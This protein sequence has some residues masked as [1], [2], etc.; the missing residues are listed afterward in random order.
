MP[1]F[2]FVGNSLSPEETGLGKI[3]TNTT[4]RSNTISWVQI[5]TQT[6]NPLDE[7]SDTCDSKNQEKICG[8]SRRSFRI[9]NDE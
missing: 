6:R 7:Q 5:E 9:E 8:R 1:I 3:S 2:K 4:F